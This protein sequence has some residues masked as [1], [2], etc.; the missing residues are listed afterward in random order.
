MTDATLPVGFERLDRI[1]V[2]TLNR[3]PANALGLPLID[4][5]HAALDAFAET[6]ARVLVLRSAVPGFFAAGADIKHMRTLDAAGF[7]TYGES[8]RA[9]IER[10]AA[11]TRPSIAVIEG[12]ALGGGLELALAATLR[13]AS[14]GARL[15]LPEPKLG[16]I[17][18]AGG[19]QRLTRLIGRGRA[20]E[21]MLTAREI[22]GAA[23]LEFGLVNRLSDRP[24]FAAMELAELIASRSPAA[25]SAV[26]KCVD[27]AEEL[28][29][30]KGLAHEAARE[31]ELFA[32]YDGQEGLRAF[33]EKRPPDFT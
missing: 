27:D 31:N 23:A 12:R 33:V 21:L 17:A 5:L 20:L 7:A 4:G 19:T 9:P 29:M 30:H 18:A 15:G 2:V 13:V 11:L 10:L 24:G 6:D 1:F 32:R 25:L 16:L 22:E 8:L 3:T 14:P 26:L 28:P